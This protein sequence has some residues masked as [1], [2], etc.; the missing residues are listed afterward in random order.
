MRIFTSTIK[1]LVLMT[2]LISCKLQEEYYQDHYR[3]RVSLTPIELEETK[4][5]ERKFYVICAAIIY[6]SFWVIIEDK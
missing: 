1:A 4:H 5:F 3:E 6:T 2:F